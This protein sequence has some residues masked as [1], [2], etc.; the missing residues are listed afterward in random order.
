MKNLLQ[1]REAKDDFFA[2]DSN[3]PLT[4]EQQKRFQ[5]LSYFPENP[6][7]T[8]ELPL[9]ELGEDQEFQ[10]QTSTGGVQVYNKLGL[11]QFSIE[12]R[13]AEL[14]IFFNEHGPFLP[15]VDSQAGVDTYGAGRYLEP[16]E[17][18]NGR[19][20]VDFNLAYNPYC[21]Y[22]DLYSCPITPWEN[23]IKVPIRAGEKIP[24]GDWVN[25]EYLQGTDAG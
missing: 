4:P 20:Q 23:R 14:L 1:F 7:L 10:F 2:K 22:N 13:A 18:S 9:K 15:F 8:L 11:I 19:F 6:T 5:G 21:A 12:G 17:L 3:S 25:H 16:L 24:Q